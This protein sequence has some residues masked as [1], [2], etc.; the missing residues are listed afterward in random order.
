MTITIQNSHF[1]AIMILTITGI[2]VIVGVTVWYVVKRRCSA[3]KLGKLPDS[4][5]N[6]AVVVDH[7]QTNGK[8]RSSFLQARQK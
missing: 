2:A 8:H 1:A 5:A 4:D 6:V 7:R 3:E